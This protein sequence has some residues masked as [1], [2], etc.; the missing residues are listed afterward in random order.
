MTKTLRRPLTAF[1]WIAAIGICYAPVFAQTACNDMQAS[2]YFQPLTDGNGARYP[3]T[4]G[5]LS[6]RLLGDA[7]QPVK[8]SD[9]M[10]H[11]AY[12]LLFTNSW[13]RAATVKSLEVVDPAR[14]NAAT[15]KNEVIS[16]KN[17]DITSKLRLFATA[18]TLDKANFSTELAAGICRRLLRCH[19]SRAFASATGHRTSRD[20]YHSGQSEQDAE[21]HRTH[22]SAAAEPL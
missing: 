19:L 22:S 18:Q 5:P 4:I 3:L 15:G 12:A 14:G 7:I 10:T 1:A 11:L 9:G 8:G 16:I 13:N 21:L 20:R 6:W 2:D 17:E